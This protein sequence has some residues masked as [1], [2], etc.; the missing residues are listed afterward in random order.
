MRVIGT[1]KQLEPVDSVDVV[2]PLNKIRQYIPQADFIVIA[3]PL[4]SYTEN[5]I[6]AAEFSVMKEDSYLI[7]V[8][9]GRIVDEKAMMMT[10][11]E[12]G[13]GGVYLDCH[14]EE[15]LPEDHPLWDMENV[16]VIPHDS[17]SSPFIGNRIVDIFCD[18]L[19]RYVRGDPLLHVCDPKKGY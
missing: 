1:K 3:I 2:F 14:V 11:M 4:T 13:I 18:N 19:E 10:L 7:N 8:G 16:L 12:G 9:R 17:H 15:P 6:G 5:I